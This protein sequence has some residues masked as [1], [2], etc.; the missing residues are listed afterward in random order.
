MKIEDSTLVTMSASNQRSLA[1]T[2]KNYK[3]FSSTATLATKLINGTPST[4]VQPKRSKAKRDLSDP[5]ASGTQ[6]KSKTLSNVLSSTMRAKK[7]PTHQVASISSLQRKGKS[8]T[9]QNG[10]KPTAHSQTSFLQ[11]CPTTKSQQDLH[12][13]VKPCKTQTAYHASAT[14]L[15]LKRLK[16]QQKAAQPSAHGKPDQNGTP[17]F[18]SRSKDRKKASVGAWL[19]SGPLAHTKQ[20]VADTAVSLTQSLD[21]LQAPTVGSPT[22]NLG[23]SINLKASHVTLQHDEGTQ[24]EDTGRKPGFKSAKFRSEKEPN[25]CVIDLQKEVGRQASNH[26]SKES[27]SAIVSP[28]LKTT[29]SPNQLS[30]KMPQTNLALSSSKHF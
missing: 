10:A 9:G 5:P 11:K 19:A 28:M 23:T 26:D 2:G 21:Q 24:E 4:Q 15:Y 16:S 17:D 27:K 20:P 12:H 22:S 25:F 13:G 6:Q 14:H 7:V 1:K 3:N 29:M 18:S 30:S 8:Q